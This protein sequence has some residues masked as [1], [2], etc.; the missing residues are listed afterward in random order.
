MTPPK[1]VEELIAVLATETAPKFVFFWGHQPAP[2]GSVT[3]SCFS[4]WW[5]SPFTIDG[6][7][8]RTAEHFM[9]AS[10]ARLFGDTPTL[11]RIL[12]AGHPKQAKDLGRSVAGFDEALW[13][14]C[15]FEFVVTGNQAKFSQHPDLAAFLLATGQRVLVEAS[16]LDRIWGIGLTADSPD[17]SRLQP[18]PPRSER[19]RKRSS[20]F[21]IPP[22]PPRTPRSPPRGA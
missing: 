1:S 21:A 18:L 6:V 10:K 8:Y 12:A 16:P 14:A 5:S 11:E 4:Q 2:D 19:H 3:K 15:R 7:E 13:L 22:H 9:M 17:A 20:A